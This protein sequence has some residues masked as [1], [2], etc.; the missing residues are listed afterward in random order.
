MLLDK[1]MTMMV[2][3]RLVMHLQ[4]AATP[5]ATNVVGTDFSENPTSDNLAEL[6]NTDTLALGDILVTGSGNAQM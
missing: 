4:D 1:Q 3:R 2:Q 5:G 6:A